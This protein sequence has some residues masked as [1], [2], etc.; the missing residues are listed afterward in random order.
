MLSTNLRNQA[1]SLMPVLKPVLSLRSR[2][3]KTFYFR[4]IQDKAAPPIIT[5]HSL[6]GPPVA[7]SPAQS[8]STY[9]I[10]ENVL[11]GP[12]YFKPNA[13]FSRHIESL[14]A[15]PLNNL[16]LEYR[17]NFKSTNRISKIRA[18]IDH[19]IHDTANQ[20][21]IWFHSWLCF[22]Y[23]SNIIIHVRVLPVC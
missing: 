8:I 2:K 20:I 16:Q 1:I 22:L 18:C 4:A 14:V 15:C 17:W 11:P 12:E 6:T 9:E 10:G 19:D 13:C 23:V 3:N 7:T 5:K 21:V